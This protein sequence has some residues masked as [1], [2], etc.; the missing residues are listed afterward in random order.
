MRERSITG[1]PSFFF[2]GRDKPPLGKKNRQFALSLARFFPPSLVTIESETAAWS[3]AA[4]RR[5]KVV[6]STS[7]EVIEEAGAA[8]EAA[9]ERPECKDGAAAAT[10]ACLPPPSTA[11]AQ[12]TA[13]ATTRALR[14]QAIAAV[15]V[16]FFFVF[17]PDEEG[18]RAKEERG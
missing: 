17:A 1:A 18:A 14:P 9:S 13:A 10:D 8:A 16:S 12:T 5:A 15:F 11:E 2:L 6:F 3:S 4:S 7:A